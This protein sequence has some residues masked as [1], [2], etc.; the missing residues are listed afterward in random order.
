MIFDTL[1]SDPAML[2]SFVNTRLRDNYDSL[3]KLCDDMNVDPDSLQRT[4]RE[5]GY[6]YD[7]TLNKFV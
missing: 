6:E 5:I 7:E 3:Q 2:L 1:P 4:L